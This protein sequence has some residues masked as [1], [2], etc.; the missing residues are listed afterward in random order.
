MRAGAADPKRT[1]KAKAILDLIESGD[2]T[3]DDAM[4]QLT[5]L[6]KGGSKQYVPAIKKG[7]D[8]KLVQKYC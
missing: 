8:D 5:K 1:A 3:T 7:M 6:D 2:I 4:A